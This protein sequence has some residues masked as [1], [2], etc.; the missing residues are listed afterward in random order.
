MA[1]KEIVTQITQIY[2]IYLKIFIK[3][4]FCSL[5][6]TKKPA[7][8]VSLDQN[9]DFNPKN[10]HVN[11]VNH[12]NLRYYC[13]ATDSVRTRDFPFEQIDP[14]AEL[15][16]LIKKRAAKRIKTP[17]SSFFWQKLTYLIQQNH[18]I[19]AQDERDLL[20]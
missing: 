12:V 1:E 5:F 11:H 19:L 6:I 14:I 16:S 20:Q 2:L 17:R 7:K 3:Y 8:K 10:F 13:S 4:S 15:E 18:F 9:S